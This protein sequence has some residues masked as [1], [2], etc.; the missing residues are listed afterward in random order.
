MS[1]SLCV[2]KAAQIEGA[3]LDIVPYALCPAHNLMSPQSK[4]VPELTSPKTAIRAAHF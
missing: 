2:F 4:A 3:S 1:Y